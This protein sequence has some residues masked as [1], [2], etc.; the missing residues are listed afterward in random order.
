MV[1]GAAWCARHGNVLG[2][3]VNRLQ[4]YAFLS[5][6]VCLCATKSSCKFFLSHFVAKGVNG[7]C[8]VAV[9]TEKNTKF[10][11]GYRIRRRAIRACSDTV[12]NNSP[13]ITPTSIMR[14][15]PAA[16]LILEDGTIFCGH[17]FGYD[18]AGTSGEV[19]FNTAM[20]GYPESLTDPSYEGQILVTTFPLQGNYGVPAADAPASALSDNFES[21]RIHCRGFVCQDYS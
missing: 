4:S 21:E 11:D 5:E 7:S 18:A 6:Y 8:S 15:T 20:T 17:S 16:R 3:Q 13:N 10:A 1:S 12:S 9:V 19:V 14:Q 2:P